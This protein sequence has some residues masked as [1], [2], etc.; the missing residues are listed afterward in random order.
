MPKLH[1]SHVL[2]CPSYLM[3]SGAKYSGVP[4]NVKLILFV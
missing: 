1:R 3:I 4:A 2:V